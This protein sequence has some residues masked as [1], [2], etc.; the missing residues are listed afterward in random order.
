MKNQNEKIKSDA[1][2]FCSKEFLDLS[3]DLLCQQ[4][5]LLDYSSQNPIGFIIFYIVSIL[6][7]AG[8]FQLTKININ[9]KD[10][11]TK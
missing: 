4:K 11:K 6:I 7:I 9:T 8:L 2:E 3:E 10:K 1:F 5:E